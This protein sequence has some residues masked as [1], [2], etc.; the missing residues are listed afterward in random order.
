MT[1]TRGSDTKVVSVMKLCSCGGHCLQLPQ[2]GQSVTSLTLHP[3][4][5]DKW[6]EKTESWQIHRIINTGMY[7]KLVSLFYVFLSVHVSFSISISWFMFWSSSISTSSSFWT[8]AV[9]LCRV[10]ICVSAQDGIEGHRYS[11]VGYSVTVAR[12]FSWT[13]IPQN[14]WRTGWLLGS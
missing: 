7:A 8:P 1:P 13:V 5:Q 3:R 12:C 14:N 9:I 6:H 2:R 10:W 11:P 4:I